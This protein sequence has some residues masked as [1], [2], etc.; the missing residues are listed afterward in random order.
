MNQRFLFV[1]Y[2]VLIMVF[3][4]GCHNEI[5][6]SKV[7]PMKLRIV[8]NN[9]KVFAFEYCLTN[10]YPEDIWVYQDLDRLGKAYFLTSKNDE[11]IFL[12]S[13]RAHENMAIENQPVTKYIRIKPGEMIRETISLDLPIARSQSKI[14]FIKPTINFEDGSG[15]RTFTQMVFK[16]GYHKGNLEKQHAEYLLDMEKSLSTTNVPKEVRDIYMKQ[17][18]SDDSD[19]LILGCGEAMESELQFTQTISGISIPVRL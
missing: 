19:S 6:D 14:R 12:S 8:E 16:L 2:P 15:E 18:A 4:V 5:R 1:K 13:M 10:P 11:L 7:N 3:V 17:F 9:S